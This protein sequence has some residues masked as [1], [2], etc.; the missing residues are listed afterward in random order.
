[1]VSKSNSLN[2]SNSIIEE[3][4]EEIRIILITFLI[5]HIILSLAFFTSSMYIIGGVELVSI[6]CYTYC[7]NKLR[8]Y[9][10]Y[11]FQ[12][13]DEESHLSIRKDLVKVVALTC[14]ELTIHMGIATILC[15]LGYNFHHYMYFILIIVMFEYYLEGNLKH[16]VL[17]LSSVTV[18][19]IIS[20]ILVKAW[21]SY[22][23]SYNS[24][25]ERLVSNINPLVT[26]GLISY[27]VIVVVKTMLAFE[28]SLLFNATHDILTELP[29]RHLLNELEYVDN[30][31]YVA[32]MDID[33]FKKINDTYGHDIGDI[34]LRS[35]SKI[36]KKYCMNYDNLNAMRWG[37]EEFVLVYT[38]QDTTLDDFV[39]L[40]EEFR[41]DVAEDTIV[42]KAKE[43]FKY[44]LTI[45]V[46]SYS[47]G[48]DLEDLI[49]VA[50]ERLYTGKKTGRNKIV[51][52]DKGEVL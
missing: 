40:L 20:Q 36:I 49:K 38:N 24:T 14:I 16:F 26:L 45:G 31:S 18:T 17:L 33:Y 52:N 19:Y 34:A 22:Y 6:L 44:H 11:A 8:I 35:L 7:L 23:I 2:V 21:G 51:F 47:D 25:C 3:F 4:L 42:I 39:K 15:G 29:N 1:M 37:G 48:D 28:K 43:S 46:S 30:A 12:I 32:M 13:Q 50:D 9:P 10:K 41:S 27:L 5:G